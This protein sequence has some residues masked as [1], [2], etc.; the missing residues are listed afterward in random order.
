MCPGCWWTS[1]ISIDCV[2]SGQGG[3]KPGF[4]LT[5]HG[6]DDILY[7]SRVMR[8]SSDR[9]GTRR[10]HCGC[11]ASIS[12]FETFTL[13][14][15]GIWTPRISSNEENF[16]FTNLSRVTKGNVAGIYS[17]ITEYAPTRPYP[18]VGVTKVIW[19][20]TGRVNTNPVVSCRVAVHK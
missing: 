4:S 7:L 16:E 13:C 11:G 15:R 1:E 9:W 2:R 10:R 14:I 17:A 20:C 3:W 8:G 6:I 5:N 18:A 19:V 12:D